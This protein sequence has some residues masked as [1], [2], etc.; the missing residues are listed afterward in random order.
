MTSNYE[1]ALEW[2]ELELNPVILNGKLDFPKCTFADAAFVWAADAKVDGQKNV[3]SYFSFSDP[4]AEELVLLSAEHYQ[5]YDVC[6]RI[7]GVHVS[8]NHPLPEALR[9]FAGAVL[10]GKAPRPSPSHR[11]R[12]QNW[13]ELQFLY[14]LCHHA[15]SRFEL[16]LTSGE[17]TAKESACDALAEALRRKG[18]TKK[19]RELRDLLTHKSKQRLRSE[20]EAAKRLAELSPPKILNALRPDYHSER[21][22]L[23]DL[24]SRIVHNTLS[25]REEKR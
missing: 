25:D 7:C 9:L 6:T 24:I 17:Y 4:V 2:L 18:V 3:D 19:A 23:A 11:E 8:G 16:N 13:L 12:K 1:R 21:E 20:F 22:L 5:F 15:A 10:L 14:T